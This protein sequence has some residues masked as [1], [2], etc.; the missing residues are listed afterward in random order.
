MIPILD[1]EPL[2]LPALGALH[3]DLWSALCNIADLHHTD[4]TVIGG[5]MVMLHGLQANQSPGRV[6]QDLDLV[7]DARVRP[8][9][10][11]AFIATLGDLGFTSTGVSPDDV[12]HRFGHGKVRI[13][14]VSPDGV[15]GRADLRTVGSA[16]TVE[17]RG[18]TQALHRTERVPVQHKKRT[19]LVPRPNLLGAIVIKSA[20][21]SSDH[22]PQRHLRDL[23]FLCGLAADPFELKSN[24][25]PS[26]RRCLRASSVL[27]N[28][29][30][31]A[32]RQLDDPDA[33]YATYR[34]LQAT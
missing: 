26:D 13:D 6:S 19:A 21:V 28:Q 3:D 20:A 2:R 12:A 30:H 33:A 14:V 4:W 1:I 29:N 24:L 27:D 32:W 16:T 22:Y 23:A 5:Q 10:T 18:G 11:P 17:V 25:T 31:Q 8:P 34:L 15:G 7:I 9:A